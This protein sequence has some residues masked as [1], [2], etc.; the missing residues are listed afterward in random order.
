MQLEVENI[1]KSVKITD[2][3]NHKTH[4]RMIPKK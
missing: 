1:N 2:V 3:T 4:K